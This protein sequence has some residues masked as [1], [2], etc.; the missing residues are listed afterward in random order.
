MQPLKTALLRTNGQ[1][2]IAEPSVRFKIAAVGKTPRKVASAI[3]Q[4]ICGQQRHDRIP[5]VAGLSVA[6][7][8][9]HWATLAVN[10][11]MNSNSINL[12]VALGE[13]GRDFACCYRP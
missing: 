12:G 4:L 10:G 1:G 9:N 7:Q 5:H 2:R 3:F 6:V 8:Q 11:V 13:T